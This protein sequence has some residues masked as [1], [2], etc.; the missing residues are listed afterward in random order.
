[1]SSKIPRKS[2]PETGKGDRLSDA[3]YAKILALLFEGKLPA[4]A[5]FAQR[6]LVQKIGVPVG[7]LRDALRVLE[8]EGLLTIHP[9]TGIEIIKPGFELIRSTYEFRRI[10]ETTAISVYS[11]MVGDAELAELERRHRIIIDQ[12]GRD[13]LNEKAVSEIEE[14]ETLLHHAIVHSLSNPLIDNAYKRIHNY[15]RL[16]RLSRKVSAP[17]VLRSLGEHMQ[18]IE[19]CK[20][21][22]T[23]AAIL[24]LRTHFDAALQRSLGILR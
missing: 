15:F 4:G 6:E 11:E 24:A 20:S 1:V 17:L 9:R 8:A 10:I 21:R 18:I 22:D 7:P 23:G 19:A 13:G 3:A 16:I 12:I 2:A 5:M 14:L